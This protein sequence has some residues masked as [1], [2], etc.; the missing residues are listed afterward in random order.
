[1]TIRCILVQGLEEC[2]RE[3]I[4]ESCYLF[5]KRETENKLIGCAS[6]YSSKIQINGIAEPPKVLLS[7]DPKS[8]KGMAVITEKVT[9]W[10]RIE[11]DNCFKI[12]SGSNLMGRSSMILLQLKR[13]D[14]ENWVIEKGYPYAIIRNPIMVENDYEMVLKVFDLLADLGNPYNREEALL[15]PHHHSNEYRIDVENATLC[16]NGSAWF[17]F[18]DF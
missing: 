6:C 2:F 10:F 5:V 18:P 16:V 14:Y 12:C 13:T 4:D 15:E 3:K 8:I 7:I 11:N 17:S 1:M 9:Y